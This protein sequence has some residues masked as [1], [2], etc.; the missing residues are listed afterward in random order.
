MCKLKG[1][2]KGSKTWKYNSM[3]L[4]QNLEVREV[5]YSTENISF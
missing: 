4:L 2:Q 5:Y 1:T 3:G